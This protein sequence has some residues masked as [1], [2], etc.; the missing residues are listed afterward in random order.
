[1]AAFCTYERLFLVMVAAALISG[2]AFVTQ[3][4]W[5]LRGSDLGFEFFDFEG[6]FNQLHRS[7]LLFFSS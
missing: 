7:I 5:G 6:N 1:M 2:L 4:P 3:Q